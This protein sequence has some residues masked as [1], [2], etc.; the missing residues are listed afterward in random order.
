[1]IGEQNTM[2]DVVIEAVIKKMEE[3]DDIF[4]LVADFGAPALDIMREKFPDRFI[5]VGIAEQNLINVATGLA[6]EGF[7]VFAYAIAPFISMRCYEQIRVNLAILSEVRELNVNLIGVGAG[8]SYV[9]SGPTHHCLE[10]ISIMNTLPNLNVVSP[11]DWQTAEAYVDF[12][13]EQKSPK[14]FRFDAKPAPALYENAGQINIK[15][16]FQVLNDGQDVLLVSTG[17]MTHKAKDVVEHF[18]K[19]GKNIGMVDVNRIKGLDKAEMLKVIEQYNSVIVMEEGFTG[20][21]GMDSVIGGLV[22]QSEKAIKFIGLGLEDKYIFH[23][24]SRE[25][26]HEQNNIGFQDVVDK[27]NSFLP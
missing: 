18:S 6:L 10:D 1:M 22:H 2:R 21:G 16:G 4:F 12:M 19:E 3:Q 13:L 11:A 17:I 15:N 7:T 24:G 5:N 8:F 23:I 9:V 27:V 26:L 14:Y 20:K 25:Y